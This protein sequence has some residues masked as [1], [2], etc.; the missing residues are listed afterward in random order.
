MPDWDIAVIGA[1]AAGLSA[2]TTAA[3]AGAA[4]LLLDRMG[5]GG[6]LMNL[7]D[8]PGHAPGPDLAASLLEGAIAAGAELAIAEVEALRATPDGWRI[9]TDGE[10]HTARAV[11]LAPG[12]AP[13]S[14]GLAEETSF[15]GQGLSHCATCDGPLYAGQA[16]VV[17]GADPWAVREARELIALGCAVTLLTQGD[18]VP[19]TAPCPV[20]DGRITALIGTPGLEAII[21]RETRADA[22]SDHQEEGRRLPARAVFVQSGRRPALGFAPAELARDAEGRIITDAEGRTNLANLLAAGD[23]RAGGARTLVAARDDGRKAAMR[24]IADRSVEA[25][26]AT[27]LGKT[28]GSA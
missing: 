13:G 23:A 22:P 5:G 26:P 12:L 14:L 21:V 4:T 2:A 24:A 15:E 8:I 3:A 1:G 6:E 16:V 18:P 20:L 25:P 9:E 10:T 7:G 19:A 28:A 11:I 17:T 27:P